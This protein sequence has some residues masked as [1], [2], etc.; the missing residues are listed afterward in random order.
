M[1]IGDKYVIRVPTPI[2][3]PFCNF[4]S[5]WLKWVREIEGT[6][7]ELAEQSDMFYNDYSARAVGW[8]VVSDIIVGGIVAWIPLEWLRRDATYPG[9]CDSCGGFRKHRLRCPRG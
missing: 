3:D 4:D 7:V 8:S 2:P 6:T 5:D 1:N 9:F